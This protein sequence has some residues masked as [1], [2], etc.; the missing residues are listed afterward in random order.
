M[1]HKLP[2]KNIAHSESLFDIFRCSPKMYGG[3]KAS[4]AISV[5][6]LMTKTASENALKS[7]HLPSGNVESQ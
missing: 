6:K 5:M 2:S 4:S 7:R 1:A 3:G